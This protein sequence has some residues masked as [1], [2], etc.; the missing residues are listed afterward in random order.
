MRVEDVRLELVDQT[1]ERADRG[2]VRQGLD[3]ALKLGNEDRLDAALARD[4]FHRAL[5]FADVA[6]DELR[7]V[8]D[9]VE[10]GRQ[11]GN[12][13]RRTAHVQP[14]DHTKNANRLSGGHGQSV[15]TSGTR[16][17]TEPAP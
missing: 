10:L 8:A 14:G 6:R 5:A 16:T 9:L 3:V 11:V 2:G 4:V 17:V 13:Q 15:A 7:L 1:Q 12:V